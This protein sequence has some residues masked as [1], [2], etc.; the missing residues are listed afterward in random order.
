MRYLKYL[1]IFIILVFLLLLFPRKIL[2]KSIDCKNQF[3]GCSDEVINS[4]N[5]ASN[6]N[7]PSSIRTLKQILRNENLIIDYSIQYKLPD[8]IH[9][10]II[11]KVAK[12]S[13][14]GT[15]NNK[16][17]QAGKNGE[18]LSIVDISNLPTLEID[19]RI[20]NVGES[21]PS[22]YKFALEI[23]ESLSKIY[24]V[25]GGKIQGRQLHVVLGVSK[26]VIFPIEGDRD[27]LL[28]SLSLVLSNLDSKRNETLSNGT[29]DIPLTIDLRFKNPVIR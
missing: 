29:R 17:A 8:K 9:V 24:Q 19:G 23:L 26:T 21:V 15:I 18:I 11:E 14:K 3:G 6:Q 28:G 22:E 10:N 1:S 25:R 7:L 12:F 13:L 5:T 20:P 4:L 27:V 2:I 16:I